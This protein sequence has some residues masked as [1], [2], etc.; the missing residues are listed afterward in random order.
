M[1]LTYEEYQA[2]GGTL[3]ATAY[4]LY[5][6]K[7]RAEIDWVTFNRLKNDTTFSE[8]VKMCMYAIIGELQKIDALSA[9][10]TMQSED[11]GETSAAVA[12][13][14]ND[15]VSMSYNQMSAS[16]GIESAKADIRDTINKYLQGVTNEL[17]RKVLYRGLYPNE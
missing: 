12:S 3:D 6:F 5:E 1:Y 16:D 14:S 8:E 9:V 17:G 2:L 7:A 4:P 15:G 10:V 13:M 11:A